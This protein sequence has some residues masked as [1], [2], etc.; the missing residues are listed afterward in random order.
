[1]VIKGLIFQHDGFEMGC[2]PIEIDD[3]L[4]AMC[5]MNSPER[6]IHGELEAYVGLFWK[7]YLKH[8]ER[9]EGR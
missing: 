6:F 7:Q 8:K 2:D 9:H 1:M 3:A 5:P 4:I